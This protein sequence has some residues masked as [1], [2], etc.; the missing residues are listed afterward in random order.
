MWTT[1]PN[2]HGSSFSV[3]DMSLGHHAQSKMLLVKVIMNLKEGK[4]QIKQNTVSDLSQILPSTFFVFLRTIMTKIRKGKECDPKDH[5][6]W[7]FTFYL[8][9]CIVPTYLSTC[10]PTYIATY[11]S[12]Y[13]P[14]YLTSVPS[15]P[16]IP[17]IP[18]IPSVHPSEVVILFSTIPGFRACFNMKSLL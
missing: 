10:L 7:Y 9:I 13:L 11:L 3:T 17:S 2:T 18:S 4:K 6:A 1:I 5:F 15:V 12:T 16:P 14:D 8:P